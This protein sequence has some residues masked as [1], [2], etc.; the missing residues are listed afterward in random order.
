MIKKSP[1]E[2]SRIRQST[3]TTAHAC[4]MFVEKYSIITQSDFNILL[5]KL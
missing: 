5:A 3:A 2:S 4:H 1:E